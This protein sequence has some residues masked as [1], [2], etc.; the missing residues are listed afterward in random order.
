MGV[1]VEKIVKGIFLSPSMILKV[2]LLVYRV[3]SSIMIIETSDGKILH[4]KKSFPNLLL[5]SGTPKIV[6]PIKELFIFSTSKKVV[7]RD[8][9]V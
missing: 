8:S 1:T 3:I 4:H 9:I 5:S 7:E 2:S 6:T